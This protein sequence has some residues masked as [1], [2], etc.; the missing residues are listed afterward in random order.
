MA[1]FEKI[2]AI[3]LNNSYSNAIQKLLEKY[4]IE[5][6]FFGVGLPFH[7]RYLAK[8]NENTKLVDFVIF[9]QEENQVRVHFETIQIF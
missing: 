1:D 4:E 3:K 2:A 8:V 9:I 7:N 5:N 6:I